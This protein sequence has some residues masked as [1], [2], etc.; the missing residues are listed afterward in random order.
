M[1]FRVFFAIAML[2]DLDIDQINVKTAF[3]YGFINQL[4]YI[5]ISKDIKIK[6]NCNIICKLLKTLYKLKQSSHF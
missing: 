3:L 2:F 6:G 4:F 5:E 1:A